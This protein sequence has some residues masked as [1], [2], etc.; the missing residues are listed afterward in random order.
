MLTKHS[1]SS[2]CQL[3]LEFWRH[4]ASW[5]GIARTARSNAV[6][7][8]KHAKTRY[9]VKRT[10]AAARYAQRMVRYCLKEAARLRTLD[11]LP[12]GEFVSLH[13]EAREMFFE[14]GDAH[15]GRFKEGVLK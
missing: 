3:E 12:H 13:T 9:L 6:L 14:I 8:Q 1:R 7:F 15:G 4:A 5:R 2:V 11:S 10:R